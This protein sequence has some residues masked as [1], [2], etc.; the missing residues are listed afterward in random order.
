MIP[1]IANTPEIYLSEADAERLRGLLF[2]IPRPKRELLEQELERAEILPDERLPAQIITMNS[3]VEF[4]DEATGERK[5]VSLVFPHDSDAAHGR[6]SVLAP[7]GT[8]LLGMSVGQRV[9]W[10]MPDGRFRTLKVLS[11]GREEEAPVPS[12]RSPP[13]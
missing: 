11:V 3:R 8:A 9:S 12:E 10:P 13:A 1:E 6:V 2:Q 7:V 5:T 4:Q